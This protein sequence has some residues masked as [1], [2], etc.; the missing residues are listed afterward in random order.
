MSLALACL[1]CLTCRLYLR[2]SRRRNKDGTVMSYLQLAHNER[3]PRTGSPV[4]RVIH[5]FGRAD[6]VDRAAL[7]RLVASISRFL[8]PEQAAAAAASAD[9]YLFD[10]TT[11]AQI[12]TTDRQ[13]QERAGEQSA[14]ETG[15][16]G[17]TPQ[18]EPG[19]LPAPAQETR[20]ARRRPIRYGNVHSHEELQR[21]AEMHRSVLSIREEA[22]PQE[23]DFTRRLGEQLNQIMH[24][25]A[26]SHEG[27]DDATAVQ[28]GYV[29]YKQGDRPESEWVLIGSDKL[30]PE[31]VEEIRRR[32][33]V[34]LDDPAD[35]TFSTIPVSLILQ[36]VTG[37]VRGRQ[38]V[39]TLGID[40]HRNIRQLKFSPTDR[41][42]LST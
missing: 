4:A 5:N 17:E 41:V 7:A 30:T 36:F 19:D 40:T 38:I 34:A 26:Q 23:D 32:L 37:R 28:M 1:D 16:Q 27:A 42:A 22:S 21:I 25:L 18:Q 3:H 9:G 20:S 13:A 35:N 12:P 31:L 15:R 24:Q 14:E 33:E 2:E 10:L 8:E 6:L 11:S 39:E 29:S